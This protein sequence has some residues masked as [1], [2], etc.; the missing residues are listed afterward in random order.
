MD[1]IFQATMSHDYMIS[2]IAIG[3]YVDKKHSR[4][5]H[6]RKKYTPWKRDNIYSINKFW[7]SSCLFSGL[8]FFHSSVSRVRLTW[9][10]LGVYNAS[11]GY[12]KGRN[13]K[14]YFNE[15]VSSIDFGFNIQPY[16]NLIPERV[17]KSL[18]FHRWV[19]PDFSATRAGSVLLRS[20]FKATF[21]SQGMGMVA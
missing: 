9:R 11:E 10:N 7:V 21:T 4:K 16:P 17:H 3:C 13:M 6:G 1:L 20:L 15:A 18:G 2:L 12:A 8:P 19:F 5:L 14:H